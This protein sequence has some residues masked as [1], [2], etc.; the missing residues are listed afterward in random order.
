M[1]LKDL[2][3]EQLQKLIEELERKLALVLEESR[4][5]AYDKHKNRS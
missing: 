5:R 4:R 1:K 3:D 2:T